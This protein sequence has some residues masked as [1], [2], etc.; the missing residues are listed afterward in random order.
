M[1]KSATKCNKTLGKWC[2]N[3]HGA[4]K[5]MDMLEMYHEAAHHKQKEAHEGIR[6]RKGKTAQEKGEEHHP[7]TISGLADSFSAGEDNLVVVRDETLRSGLVQ[8]LLRKDRRYP[9][10]RGVHPLGHLVFLR[11]VLHAHLQSAHGG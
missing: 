3:K 8:F 4:S 5:I 10:G 11:L 1:H 2:K 9:A 7:K 6:G